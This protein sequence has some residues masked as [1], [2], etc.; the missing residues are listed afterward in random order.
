MP[1]KYSL[2]Q[3]PL[4]KYLKQPVFEPNSKTI[5]DPR[6]YWRCYQVEMLERCLA[7]EFTSKDLGRD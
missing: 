1:A 3:F 5:L 4:W 2:M 7:I 6:R